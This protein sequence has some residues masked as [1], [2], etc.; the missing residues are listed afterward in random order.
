MFSLRFGISLLTATLAG[1]TTYNCVTFSAPGASSTSISGINNSSMIVGSYTANGVTHGFIS[2]ATS[3]SFRTVDYPGSTNTRLFAINNNGIATGEYNFSSGQTPGWFTIDSNG[4]FTPFTVPGYQI[5]SIYGIN[6][7]GAISAYLLSGPATSFAIVAPGGGVTLVPGGTNVDDPNLA[8]SINSTPLM[9][10]SDNTYG[11]SNLADASGGLTKISYPYPGASVVRTYAFGL[12]NGGTVAGYFTLSPIS[13]PPFLGFTRD[14]SGAY[15]E[16]LCPG[17]PSFNLPGWQ[18]IND[19]GVI[20]GG[21]YIGTPISGE[22]QVSVSSNSL[23]FPP[24]PIGQTS[25]PQSVTLTNSGNA[26]LDIAAISASRD[27]RVTGCLDPTTHTASLDPGSSCDLVVTAIPSATGQRTGTITIDDSA[28][29]APQQPIALSVFGTLAAPYCQISSVTPAQVTFTMQDTSSGLSSILL[30][31]STN[32]N[33]TIPSFS[34]GTTSPVNVTASQVDSSQSSKVDFKVTNKAGGATSCGATFGGPTGWTGIGG[35]FSGKIV[36]VS[37]TDGRLQDFVRGTDDALWTI[38]QN[39]PDTGWTAWQSLGGTITT[40]PS[41]AVNSDGRLEAFAI[42]TD[43]ALWHIWQTSAGGPWS[44]W[45]TLGG[46][47]VSDPAA[48][49][50]KDGRLEVFAV[51]NDHA[52]WHIW[53]ISAGGGWSDW[54]PLGGAIASNPSVVLNTDGRL[55]VFAVRTDHLL[56]HIAQTAVNSGWGGWSSLNGS[57]TGD[58]APVVNQDGRLEVFA[59]GTDDQLWHVFQMTAGGNWAAFSALGGVLSSNPGVALNAD[60]RLEAFVRGADN[61]LWHIAQTAVNSGWA[62]WETLGGVLAN[63]P[64]AALNQDGRL[65]AF[66]EGTDTAL[67]YIEQTAP[68][69]WN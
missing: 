53:Q 37:N 57:L 50:N 25:A 5:L 65:E 63:G 52:L 23:V 9:L 38:A 26:R 41:V 17:V 68:G 15:S 19:N 14:P 59:R 49:T 10:E 24:T 62:G 43:G 42:G 32:A 21:T 7:Q 36:T 16:A 12:N 8:G 11:T 48:V 51:G 66:V 64:T 2:T 20:A 44:G 29:G 54:N 33:V 47:I 18:A 13:E 27:F 30:V 39:S 60:G 22:P 31:D 46:G 3:S 35:A 67:W 40:D 45:Q 34:S 69:F 1:A 55:E 58:P 56:W 4:T 28:P 6:D 61:A